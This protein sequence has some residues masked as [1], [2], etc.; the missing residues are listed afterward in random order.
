MTPV[1]TLIFSLYF[2]DGSHIDADYAARY[3]SLQQCEKAR[4][5]ELAPMIQENNVNHFYK[6]IEAYCVSSGT[7]GRKSSKRGK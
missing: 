1:Y 7:V 6:K 5:V 4:M 2:L 3:T